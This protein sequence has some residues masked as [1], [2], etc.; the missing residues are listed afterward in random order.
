MAVAQV[1][2]DA[3]K[4]DIAFMGTYQNKITMGLNNE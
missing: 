2:S 4:M 3:T 1:G